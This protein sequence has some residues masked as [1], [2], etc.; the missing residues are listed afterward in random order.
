MW[1]LFN[2]K[3]EKVRG[4]GVGGGQF[5]YQSHLEF[6]KVTFL[7]WCADEQ[8]KPAEVMVLSYFWRGYQQPC[9]IGLSDRTNV[10]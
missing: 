10:A 1:C 5:S 3:K 6:L 8:A 4:K 7:S 2:K 9:D